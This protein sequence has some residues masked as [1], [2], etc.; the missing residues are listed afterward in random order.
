MKILLLLPF[1]C[2][3]STFCC[4]LS[5]S[6]RA[7]LAF[8]NISD[9]EPINIHTSIYEWETNDLQEQFAIH[10]SGLVIL[11]P[12]LPILFEKCGLTLNNAF[13]YEKSKSKAV[14]LLE[15]AATGKTDTSE[16]LLVFNKV[17]SGMEIYDE[18]DGTANITRDDKKIVEEMLNAVIHK[19][20][21]IGNTTISGLR[22]TFIVREGLLSTAD[23][24][25]QLL[26]QNSGTDILLNYL[27]WSITPSKLPWMKKVLLVNW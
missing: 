16:A 9:L 23:E 20:D 21:K 6:T 15:Y 22:G 5:N 7:Q 8:A 12:F 27:P 18:L 11:M 14:R 10:N 24:N 13:I 26:V 19:W 4:M 25:Y 1:C 3:L 17:L 2:M